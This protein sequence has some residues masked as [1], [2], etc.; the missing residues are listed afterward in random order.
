MRL[1]ASLAALLLALPVMAQEEPEP[2]DV[3]VVE[4]EEAPSR[5]VA[6]G[7]CPILSSGREE[8]PPDQPAEGEGEEEG[9]QVADGEEELACDAGVGIDLYG[10]TF[11]SGRLSLVGVLGMQSVGVGLAWT[12]EDWRPGGMRVSVGGALV[13]PYTSAGIDGSRHAFALGVT[14]GLAQRRP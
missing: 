5:V 14:L 10:R 11:V 3:E 4:E 7:W 12:V 6:A 2:V 1:A 13:A 8:K 9:E